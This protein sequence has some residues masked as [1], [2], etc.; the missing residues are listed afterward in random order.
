MIGVFSTGRMVMNRQTWL[1]AAMVTVA[2]PGCQGASNQREVLGA[3]AFRGSPISNSVVRFF[4]AT[5]RPLG[6]AVQ[7][8]GTF[9]A[10]LPPGEYTVTI[11]TGLNL[12]ETWKEGDPIP[13]NQPYVPERYR[14]RK[15]SDLRVVV[16]AGADPL[17]LAKFDLK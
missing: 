2:L 6:A 7:P 12:P 4:P 8:D 5:G 13:P 1:L 11:E 10:H 14:S 17:E 3:V 16:E 9:S 15:S